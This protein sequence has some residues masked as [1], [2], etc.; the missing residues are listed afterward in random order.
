LIYLFSF[1]KREGEKYL[2]VEK[3]FMNSINEEVEKEL[4]T[5]V[6]GECYEE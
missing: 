3:S 4:A 1:K 5:V 2:R 6:L